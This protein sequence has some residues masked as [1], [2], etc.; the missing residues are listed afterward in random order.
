MGDTRNMY[1]CG[2]NKYTKQYSLE[3]QR[4][5]LIHSS[6]THNLATSVQ[7][8]INRSWML[9]RQTIC[10]TTNS[11]TAEPYTAPSK[12]LSVPFVCPDQ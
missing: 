5:K 1:P 9:T 6:H 2:K 10:K 11:R 12:D 7:C 8:H 3:P 4:K